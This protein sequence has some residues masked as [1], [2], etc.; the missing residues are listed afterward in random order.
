MVLTLCP[1]CGAEFEGDLCLGCPACGAR[2]V[3]PPL[4]K[5][6]H[7]LPSYSR[8]LIAVASG[9]LMC[10]GLLLA[11][12]VVLAQTRPMSF[13]LGAIEYAGETAA[14]N[15]KWIELPLTIAAIW[16]S[17]RMSRAIRQSP[18]R[19]TGLWPAR[20][21]V[22]ASVIVTVIIATLI[23]VT[24]PERLLARQERHDA[25]VYAQFYRIQRALAEYRETH[26]TLP[27]SEDL[28]KELNTL[29]DLDG[30]LADALRSLD[31]NGYK[32]SAVVAEAA[33]TVKTR[34]LRGATFRNSPTS[35]SAAQID[36]GVSFTTYELRM[37]GEDK[38][39]GTDDDL[40][41]HDGVILKVSE[42]SPSA[43]ASLRSITH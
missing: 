13:R 4:A 21:G 15:L 7:E 39:L 32:P 37:P 25:A 9:A 36:H 28:A 10:A 29:P 16:L 35:S 23:G 27:S 1:A 40:I 33:T 22:I 41:L 2:A 34:G 6:Q 17:V 12:I 20:A 38:I 42:L 30:S 3:G 43:R 8:A 26:G 18:Q 5:P 19:L 14:W 11:T 31:P 24:I